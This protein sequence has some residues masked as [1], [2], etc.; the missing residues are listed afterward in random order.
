MNTIN[1]LRIQGEEIDKM[2]KHF[3]FELNKV[4]KSSLIIL[5]STIAVQ[6]V[7]LYFF[8]I[9]GRFEPSTEDDILKNYS[10]LMS[11][12][13][14]IT[15][16][17]L[18]VC[19][20]VFV[21]RVIV[22]N[23]IGDNRMRLYLYPDGKAPLYYTKNVTVIVAFGLAHL[24][25]ILVSNVIY[26]I[27]ETLFPILNSNIPVVKYIDSFLIVPIIAT[28]LTISMILGT[29]II[30]IIFASP[31]AAVV[32]GIICVSC[33]GNLLAICFSSYLPLVL[34]SSLIIM[35]IVFLAIMLM[36][37]RINREDVL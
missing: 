4:K 19:G 31:V 36:G 29:S 21:N 22:V 25:G 1:F 37:K 11:L 6:L 3:F 14:T 13:T 26:I 33:L 7:A 17:I 9:I 18:T 23:Y 12:A 30:G 32:F 20:T 10:G 2:D 35:I 34:V 8:T 28:V 16:C 24:L 27:T 5:I 15:M